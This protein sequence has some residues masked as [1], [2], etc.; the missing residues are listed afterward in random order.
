MGHNADE[1][2]LAVDGR[3]ARLQASQGSQRILTAGVKVL[4]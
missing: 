1:I 3:S 4:S 2:Q